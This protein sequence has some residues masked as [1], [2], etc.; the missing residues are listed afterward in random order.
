MLLPPSLSIAKR[1][2]VVA[3]RSVGHEPAVADGIPL[4]MAVI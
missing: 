3:I 2:V 1:Q 4:R